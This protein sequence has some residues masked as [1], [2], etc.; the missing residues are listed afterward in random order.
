[1][2]RLTHHPPALL[3]LQL[4]LLLV[5]DHDCQLS[6]PAPQEAAVID[7]RRS[8]Q[9]YSV[10][11]DH[12]LAVNIYNLSHWFS[13]EQRMSTQAEKIEVM[14]NVRNTPQLMIHVVYII[15]MQLDLN[16]KYCCFFISRMAL[17][18]RECRKQDYD[19]KFF[20]LS[21]SINDSF[22]KIFGY[23]IFSGNEELIFYID[24]LLGACNELKVGIEDGVF[25]LCLFQTN[26]PH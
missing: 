22:A 9:H 26:R 8:D 16:S 19:S 23:C 10:I 17:K 15:E 13:L 20:L 25:S 1:M 5:L 11:H 3:R 24:E 4:L 18:T 14:V 12:E 2:R 7:V 6:I 21:V